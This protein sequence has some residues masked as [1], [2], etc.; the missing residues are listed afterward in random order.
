VNPQIETG[1]STFPNRPTIRELIG[2]VNTSAF[3]R[4]KTGKGQKT[5]PR[6]ADHVVTTDRV[7]S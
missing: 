1:F 3:N 2:S 4:P 6:V 5:Y 7:P